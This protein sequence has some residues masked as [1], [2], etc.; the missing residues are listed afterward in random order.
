[1][2]R[3]YAPPPPP[4][5]HHG[6]GGGEHPPNSAVLGTTLR[7]VECAPAWEGAQGRKQ[8]LCSRGTTVALSLNNE[9][10]PGFRGEPVED[11]P[12][13]RR[14]RTYTRRYQPASSPPPP[15]PRRQ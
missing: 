12:L 11:A 2:A 13:K 1:M 10:Y 5:V 14:T 8:H 4:C 7:C 3:C 15:R 6:G 9:D